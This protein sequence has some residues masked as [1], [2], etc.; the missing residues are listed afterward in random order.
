MSCPGQSREDS[1]IVSQQPTKIKGLQKASETDQLVTHQAENRD[2]LWD[3]TL[4][5]TVLPL[6]K[7][8]VMLGKQ[9]Y[10]DEGEPRTYTQE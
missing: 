1:N 6:A 7:I 2:Q 9:V 10:I 5:M 4:M 3:D 8:G